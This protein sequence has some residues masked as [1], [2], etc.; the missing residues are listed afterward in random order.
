M[1]WK[2]CTVSEIG[3]QGDEEGWVG[4]KMGKVGTGAGWHG[5]ILSYDGC[6]V[7]EGK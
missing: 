3:E 5:R 4:M 7:M 2:I 1:R 6:G